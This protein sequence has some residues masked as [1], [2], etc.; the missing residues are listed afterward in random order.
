MGA[1]LVFPE[2]KNI[3]IAWFSDGD[4]E[5]PSQIDT[6]EKWLIENEIKL[7]KGSYVTDIG[8][9]LRKDACGSDGEVT[10]KM[11]KIMLRVGME[12]YLSE[13]PDG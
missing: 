12:L 3:K 1:V 11:M 13:Y 8:F 2:N 10:L 4:W 5:L 7:L 6:L 9:D